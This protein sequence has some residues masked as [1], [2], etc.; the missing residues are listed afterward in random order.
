MLRPE[1]PLEALS[2]SASVSREL[3]LCCLLLQLPERLADKGKYLLALSGFPCPPPGVQV[4]IAG[5]LRR[6]VHV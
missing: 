1:R 4:P 5:L 2:E 6:C 3:I